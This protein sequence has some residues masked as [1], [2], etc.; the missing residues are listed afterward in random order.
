MSNGGQLSV[1]VKGAQNTS[2][3]DGG[4]TCFVSVSKSVSHHTPDCSPPHSSLFQ[5]GMDEHKA[6]QESHVPT[7]TQQPH[8]NP[9][10][11]PFIMSAP[12]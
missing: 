1:K 10:P 6:S 11:D 4:M 12:T 9:Q 8:S 5:K 7:T 2:V 3:T